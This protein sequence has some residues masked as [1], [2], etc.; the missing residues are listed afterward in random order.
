MNISL[1]TL[2]KFLRL[3]YINPKLGSTILFIPFL[4]ILGWL[5][6]QPLNLLNVNKDDIPLIGTFLHF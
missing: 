1:K 3:F 2:K 5:L 4:Y 6:A